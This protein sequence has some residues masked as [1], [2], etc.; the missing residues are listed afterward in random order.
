M[1][2][3]DLLIKLIGVFSIIVLSTTTSSAQFRAVSLGGAVSPLHMSKQSDFAS[4]GISYNLFAAYRQGNLALRADYLWSSNYRK[5]NFSFS[6]RDYELSLVYSLRSLFNTPKINPYVRLGAAR[7]Q[8]NFTTEGYPGITDYELKVEEYSGYGAVGSVG[9]Q[10]LISNIA[11]GLEVDY[12]YRG[13]AQFIAGGFDPQ[14]LAQDELRLKL[15]ATYTIPLRPG[16][17][18]ASILCPKFKNN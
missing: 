8:T 10:Y 13:S 11:I 7:W 1:K 15:T 18:F 14:P 6:T 17:S 12:A 2:R 9:A 16:Q 5:E 3:I 4:E